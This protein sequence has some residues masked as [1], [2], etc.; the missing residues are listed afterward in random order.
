MTMML[1]KKLALDEEK[2]KLIDTTLNLELDQ[3]LPLDNLDQNIIRDDA[4][5]C[6][7]EP[8]DAIIGNPPYQSKNKAQ[9]RVRKSISK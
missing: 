1:A 9:K 6:D 5:F 7:W 2:T 3:A 8:V 4:L